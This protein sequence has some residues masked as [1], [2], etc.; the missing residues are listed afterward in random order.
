MSIKPTFPLSHF[1]THNG[2]SLLELMVVVTIM[3]ILITTSV[4]FGN[5][6]LNHTAVKNATRDV[7]S[8]MRLAHSKA[9]AMKKNYVVVFDTLNPPDHPARVWAQSY[10]IPPTPGSFDPSDTST[11]KPIFG[12]EKKL[13]KRVKIDSIY[14]TAW[15]TGGTGYYQD[16]SDPEDFGYT[17][18]Y[19]DGTAIPMTVKVCDTKDNNQYSLTVVYTSSR[20]RIKDTW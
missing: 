8:V 11:W 5:N 1:H 14:H 17:T 10:S 7:A 12:T 16:V 9:G 20:V 19:W 15:Y 6:F 4:I 13:S 2:F 3:S 18:F